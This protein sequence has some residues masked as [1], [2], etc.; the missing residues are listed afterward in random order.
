M[1]RT[2]I[3]LS[4]LAAL[5]VFIQA[6]VTLANQ[7]TQH[8]HQQPAPV[9]ERGMKMD[10]MKMDQMKMGPMKMDPSKMDGM[11]GDMMALKNANSERLNTLMADVKNST[12]EAKIAAMA[13]IIGILLTERTAMQEHCAA[14]CSMMKK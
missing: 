8:D 11:K 6:T 14:A 7:A 13:E 10:Q 1:R 12:G 5:T 4:V 3:A 9:E 2:S